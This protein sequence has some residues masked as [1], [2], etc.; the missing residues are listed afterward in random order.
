MYGNQV[1]WLPA[2]A[3]DNP[4]AASLLPAVNDWEVVAPGPMPV[5]AATLAKGRI[6]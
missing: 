2:S 5:G 3:L 4:L 1:G 6:R